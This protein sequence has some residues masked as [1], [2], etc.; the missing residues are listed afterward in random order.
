MPFI[1]H[2]K[3]ITNTKNKQKEKENYLNIIIMYMQVKLLWEKLNLA[4]V[5]IEFI[6]KL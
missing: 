4:L 1:S 3:V 6:S 2:I 5:I